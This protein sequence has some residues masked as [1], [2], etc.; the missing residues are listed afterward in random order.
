MKNQKEIR[1]R[2]K[3][4][5]PKLELA[6]DSYFST[7]QEKQSGGEIYHADFIK[8]ESEYELLKKEVD[9]LKW[10]LSNSYYERSKQEIKKEETSNERF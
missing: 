8:I 2:I 9:T 1:D 5:T 3:E 6:E 7:I 10:V 4:L